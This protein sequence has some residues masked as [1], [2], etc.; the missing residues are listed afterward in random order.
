MFL[1]RIGACII[2]LLGSIAKLE[3]VW[4]MA[5]LFLGLMALTNLA[6][7][8][9]LSNKAFKCILDFARQKKE[10]KDPVFT[11]SKIE[12]YDGAECWRNTEN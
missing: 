6:A 1:Y 2:I 12:E 10:K 7:I 8:T 9:L 5:D 3:Q 4:G 11:I